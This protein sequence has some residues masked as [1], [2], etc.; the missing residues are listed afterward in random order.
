MISSVRAIIE[1]GVAPIL[2]APLLISTAPRGAGGATFV[3]ATTAMVMGYAAGAN[4]ADGQTLI[5]VASG[6]ARFQGARRVSQGFWSNSFAD[7][8]MIPDATL[9][10][11]LVEGART[12]LCLR[13]QELDNVAWTATNVTVAADSIAAPDGTTTADTLTASAANGTVIQDLGAIAS[14]VKAWG[15]WL[16]RKTGTGNID[17]TLDGGATWTT[18]AITAAWTRVEIT[19]TLADPDIGIRIVTS[20]DAV[21]AWGGQCEAAAFL[22]TDIPTTSAAVTRNADALT[23][24][25]VGN[26]DGTKGMVSLEA[27]MN[28]SGTGTEHDLIVSSATAYPLYVGMTNKL[29]LYD[30]TAERLGNTVTPSTAIQKLAVTW[31]KTTRTY[32]AGVPSADLAFDGDLG[33]GT[34][35]SI[36]TAT[37]LSGPWFGTIR[38]VKIFDRAFSD[39]RVAGL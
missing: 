6:E 11:Y 7:G 34:T 8:T 18:T 32:I 36:G 24:P 15:L 3:R 14:A 1:A 5:A 35:I 37:D 4:A 25:A 16:K 13:S 39:S 27:S 21:Y 23:Y 20:A 12:N 9:K 2:E 31:G 29:A 38:N 33:V 26:I 19:Q 10:G 30:G 17:L 22:S 28:W